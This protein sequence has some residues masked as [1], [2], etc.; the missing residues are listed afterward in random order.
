M[1]KSLPTVTKPLKGRLGDIVRPMLQIVEFVKPDKI[2][3][4]NELIKQFDIDRKIQKSESFEAKLLE[5]I[6]VLKNSVFDDLLSIKDITDKYNENLNE[7]A[8]VTTNKVGWRLKA[9]G[10][11]KRKLNTG[12]YIELDELVITNL[13]ES[14]G[15]NLEDTPMQNN[16]GTSAEKRHKRHKRH[17]GNNTSGLSGDDNSDDLETITETSQDRHSANPTESKSGDDSDDSDDIPRVL[18]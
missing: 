2:E 14:L 7:K 9:M 16:A 10:F 11:T 18:E 12:S 1:G 15:L 13:T 4:I 5:I 6:L 17:L 3:L 8:Q